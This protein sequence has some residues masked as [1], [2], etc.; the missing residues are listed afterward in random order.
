VLVTI[1]R[2]R[3]LGFRYDV[4]PDTFFNICWYTTGLLFYEY[5]GKNVVPRYVPF[6]VGSHE[7]IMLTCTFVLRPSPEVNFSLPMRV[8]IKTLIDL[9]FRYY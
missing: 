6:C 2:L 7:S 1:I 3:C 8:S 9:F 5:A 4:R